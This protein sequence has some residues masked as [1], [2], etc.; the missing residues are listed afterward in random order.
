MDLTVWDDSA[1]Y[2]ILDDFD[3]RSWKDFAYKKQFIGCQR[4]FAITDKYKRKRTIKWGKPTIV[5]SN[6]DT[7]PWIRLNR[8]QREWYSEN[9]IRVEINIALFNI[10]TDL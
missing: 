7:D 10:T 2:L 3:D 8:N 6:D 9:C 1:L 5:I 4:E